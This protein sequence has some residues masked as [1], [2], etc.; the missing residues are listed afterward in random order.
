MELMHM[1]LSYF[2]MVLSTLMA[3]IGHVFAFKSVGLSL[4]S[5]LIQVAQFI[6]T[7]KRSKESQP[8]AYKVVETQWHTTP[9]ETSYGGGYG[10]GAYNGGGAYGGGGGAYG[11]GGGAYGGVQSKS[12]YGPVAPSAYAAPSV[13]PVRRRR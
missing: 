2:K 6:M 1:G 3:F 9:A 12:G 8:T 4:I 10:G 5:V 7:L 13:Q 11:G